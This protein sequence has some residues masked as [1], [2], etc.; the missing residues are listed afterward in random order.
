MIS[1]KAKQGTPTLSTLEAMK[2]QLV[3]MLDRNQAS[4][5]FENS[6]NKFR[7]H[8]KQYVQYIKLQL[9]TMELRQAE[10]ALLVEE[11]IQK[12]LHQKATT[13]NPLTWNR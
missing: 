4:I 2:K 13:Q 12:D 11:D 10:I 3:L 6:T 8:R 1:F 9:E 5:N 7:Q